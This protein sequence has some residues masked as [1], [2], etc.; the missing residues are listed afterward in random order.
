MAA[1]D[2]SNQEPVAHTSSIRPLDMI[3]ISETGV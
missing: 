3:R 2:Y 1:M